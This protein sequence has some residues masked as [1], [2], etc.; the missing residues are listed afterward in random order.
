MP[1]KR[2]KG[3]KPGTLY[4]NVQRTPIGANIAA[5]R[6][7][8]NMTQQQLAD[9]TGLDKTT[10][11][12]YERRAAAIPWATLQRIAEVLSVS[13]DFLLNTKPAT[14]DLSATKGLLQQLDKAKTLPPA[15]Q[16]LVADLIDNLATA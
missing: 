16:K 9:A 10:V 8:R 14:A 11:S 3:P 13:A 1:K 15:K 5:A 7:R 2:T 4:K 12:Y 6:R